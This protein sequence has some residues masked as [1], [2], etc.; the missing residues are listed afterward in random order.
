MALFLMDLPWHR[1]GKYDTL[2]YIAELMGCERLLKLRPQLVSGLLS[3]AEEPAMCSYV[4]DLVQ[5][6][7]LLHK[8]EVSAAEFE[9]AWLDPFL[10]STREPFRQLSVPLFQH[11]LPA[12]ITVHP[13]TTQFVFGKLSEGG[14]DFVPAILK[15]LL[16]DRPL[17]EAGDLER[18]RNVIDQGMCHKNVQ[19]VNRIYDSNTLLRR[20]LRKGDPSKPNPLGLELFEAHQEFIS[21][22]LRTAI[23][24]LY[25][26]ANFCRRSTAVEILCLLATTQCTKG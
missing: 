19:L 13:G 4:K 22:L 21:W 14:G 16:L 25:P 15:C 9:R 5:K 26:G 12:L 18:W 20:Q 23:D 1:K 10:E 24:Q 6:L 2:G 11:V 8:S 3:A 7:G 17:I